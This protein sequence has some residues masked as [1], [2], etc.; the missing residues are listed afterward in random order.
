M[1]TQA[2]MAKL[3]IGILLICGGM[4]AAYLVWNVLLA[5]DVVYISSRLRGLTQLIPLLT[6][7]P[8]AAAFAVWFF[9]RKKYVENRKLLDND[10][11]KFGLGLAMAVLLDA[12]FGVLGLVLVG[13]GAISATFIA[14]L[15]TLVFQVI[16]CL[17]AFIF[18]PPYS[19]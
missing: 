18:C 9:G 2:N 8:G 6:S 14:Y 1:K 19:R 3:A 4:G 13:F 12:A 10:A 7:L 5:T 17:I 15:V 16:F 11:F